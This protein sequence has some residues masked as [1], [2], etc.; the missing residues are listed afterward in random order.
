MAEA[1]STYWR[2]GRDL[3]I[4]ALIFVPPVLGRLINTPLFGYHFPF[5]ASVAF[6][7]FWIWVG[8]QFCRMNLGRT[9][10]YLL[11]ISL[12]VL[13]LILYVWQFF[14]V[15]GADRSMFLAGLSQWY[16]IPV[17]PVAAQIWS[18]FS[19]HYFDNRFVIIGYILLV[20]AFSAGYFG[21]AILG[22]R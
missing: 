22:E 2:Y 10:N 13:S 8:G 5:L 11:G 9:L 20:A 16:A 1:K 3:R 14:V 15:S 21:R 6:V 18:I 4:G 17:T 19:P 12:T 7:A